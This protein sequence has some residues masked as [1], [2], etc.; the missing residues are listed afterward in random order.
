[1]NVYPIRMD[2]FVKL[3]HVPTGITASCGYE[4]SQHRNREQAMRLL[5]AR[6]WASKNLVRPV[7]PAGE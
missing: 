2:R 6:L 1:M 3:V 5:R 4:R 7:M